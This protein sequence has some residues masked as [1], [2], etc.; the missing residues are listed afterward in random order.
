MEQGFGGSTGFFDALPEWLFLKDPETVIYYTPNNRTQDQNSTTNVTA[1]EL[2]TA[3]RSGVEQSAAAFFASFTHV[4]STSDH[5]DHGDPDVNTSQTALFGHSDF[6]QTGAA[7]GLLSEQEEPASEM[8]PTAASKGFADETS[9]RQ[10]GWAGEA[11]DL[12]SSLA[13]LSPGEESSSLRKGDARLEQLQRDSTLRKKL[14]LFLQAV[15]QEDEDHDETKTTLTRGRS[16]GSAQD[17]E[18]PSLQF[19]TPHNML[20]LI[21]TQES[22]AGAQGGQAGSADH[23]ALQVQ[24]ADNVAVAGSTSA[25]GA[26]LKEVPSLQFPTPHNMLKL[27]PDGVEAPVEQ[28][29]ADD[30]KDDSHQSFLKLEG[31]SEDQ[32]GQGQAR[33]VEKAAD[34]GVLTGG[35]VPTQKARPEDQGIP[36]AHLEGCRAQADPHFE[37]KTGVEDEQTELVKLDAGQMR[38]TGSV[39]L[40]TKT[41]TSGTGRYDAEPASEEPEKTKRNTNP[42]RRGIPVGERLG[43]G[44]T[45]ERVGG[46]QMQVEKAEAHQEAPEVDRQKTQTQLNERAPLPGVAGSSLGDYAMGEE[47][48]VATHESSQLSGPSFTQKNSLGVGVDSTMPRLPLLSPNSGGLPQV[49]SVKTT[50][51]KRDAVHDR[52]LDEYPPPGV[53]VVDVAPT[54]WQH[55]TAFFAGGDVGQRKG[56][57]FTNEWDQEIST[58]AITEIRAKMCRIMGLGIEHFYVTF[59]PAR[60]PGAE[61]LTEPEKRLEEVVVAEF[62][63]DGWIVDRPQLVWNSPKIAVFESSTCKPYVYE[64][65]GEVLANYRKIALGHV[66][67]D[68]N[69]LSELSENRRQVLKEHAEQYE[70]AKQKLESWSPAS[71]KLTSDDKEGL[72]KE[73]ATAFEGM[74]SLLLNEVDRFAKD[75]GNAVREVEVDWSSFVLLATNLHI[76]KDEGGGHRVSLKKIASVVEQ[77][78][79]A[80][81]YGAKPKANG[82]LSEKKKKKKKSGYWLCWRNCQHFVNDLANL[83]RTN[84]EEL[85][86]VSQ[87]S[88]GVG[89]AAERVRGIVEQTAAVVP[90]T[91]RQREDRYVQYFGGV[92]QGQTGAGTT[93][94]ELMVWNVGGSRLAAHKCKLKDRRLSKVKQRLTDAERVAQILQPVVQSAVDI[95]ALEDCSKEEARALDAFWKLEDAEKEKRDLTSDR[96]RLERYLEDHASTCPGTG[97]GR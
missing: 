95:K 39:T 86:N 11:H 23:S 72:K 82:Q 24:Q 81:G 97:S 9:T 55:L 85:W 65:A 15:Q 74:V 88:R 38:Q 5:S 29:P 30:K 48:N 69:T 40:Q 73:R 77:L 25:V 17:Q 62:G 66:S 13:S 64:K 33:D 12:A 43:A 46:E 27:I 35:D 60:A 21:P 51:E 20:K 34:A 52:V 80:L 59:T 18:K 10:Y 2:W 36:L 31:T 4:S 53:D 14:P 75:V 8:A 91:P 92:P 87:M 89:R 28:L 84:D 76:P 1:T 79:E 70:T 26:N 58:D 67:D 71:W 61:P 90:W 78:G 44:E 3:L 93:G 68:D 47:G 54:V 50:D 37:S 42:G 45:Q 63:P 16:G 94:K 96:D 49:Q 83:W 41:E 6:L 7:A 56:N 19:P 32:H 22:H 57:T